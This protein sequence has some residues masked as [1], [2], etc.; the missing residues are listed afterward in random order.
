MAFYRKNIKWYH[1]LWNIFGYI[2]GFA[3]LAILVV[4]LVAP[5]TYIVKGDTAVD[6]LVTGVSECLVF[7]DEKEKYYRM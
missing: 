7:L 5:F 1:R 4:T 6:R 3:S 2:I